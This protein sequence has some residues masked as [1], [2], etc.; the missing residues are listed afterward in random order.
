[1]GPYMA[2]KSWACNEMALRIVLHSVHVHANLY[3]WFMV[4]PLSISADFCVSFY[5]LI[6]TGQA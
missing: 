4:P 1:M 6:F 5:V 2:L 3:Q